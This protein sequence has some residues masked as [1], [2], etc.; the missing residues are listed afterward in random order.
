MFKVILTPR[1]K[2]V[3]CVVYPQNVHTGSSLVAMHSGSAY[4]PWVSQ[5]FSDSFQYTR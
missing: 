2:V 4:T 5:S 1:V 3:K